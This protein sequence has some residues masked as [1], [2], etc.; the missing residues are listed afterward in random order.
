LPHLVL[1]VR[2]Y[3]AADSDSDHYLVVTKVRESLAINKQRSHKFHV[4]RFNLKKLNEIDGKENFVLRS[5]I[6]LQIWMLKWKLIIL[7][8]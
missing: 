3:K 1:D 5:K 6:C 8:K 2:S 7:G 4:E